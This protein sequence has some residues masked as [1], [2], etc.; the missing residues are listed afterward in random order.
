MDVNI[1]M[2][3]STDLQHKCKYISIDGKDNDDPINDITLCHTPPPFFYNLQE[4]T[5]NLKILNFAK[6][7]YRSNVK[8]EIE[9]R[10]WIF[11]YFI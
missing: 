7:F 9:E 6:S 1:C 11:F 2:E 3:P 5:S 8:K 10:D 4:E